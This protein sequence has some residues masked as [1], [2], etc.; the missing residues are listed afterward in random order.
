MKIDM[1]NTRKVKELEKRVQE[2]DVS[3]M[4]RSYREAVEQLMDSYGSDLNQLAGIIK[5]ILDYLK[6]EHH[7]EW[8]DDPSYLRP[9]PKKMKV[10][11]L[12]KKEKGGGEK[13]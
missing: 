8:V 9:Q 10:W 1:F 11:K 2:L 3:K 7:E 13:K 12:S 6:L 4:D 5:A